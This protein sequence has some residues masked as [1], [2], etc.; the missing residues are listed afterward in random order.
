MEVLAFSHH[1]SHK[2]H[3]FSCDLGAEVLVCFSNVL[4][5][6]SQVGSLLQQVDPLESFQPQLDASRL[7]TR[8]IQS[9][10]TQSFSFLKISRCLL[11][12]GCA[13]SAVAGHRH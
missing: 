1:F 10:L 3:D 5:S 2:V 12:R 8:Q 4:D 7:E 9:L 13:F 6:I 11:P